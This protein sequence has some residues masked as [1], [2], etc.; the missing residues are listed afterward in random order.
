MLFNEPVGEFLNRKVLLGA[1]D[2]SGSF[3]LRTRSDAIA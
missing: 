2:A 1:L 3:Y